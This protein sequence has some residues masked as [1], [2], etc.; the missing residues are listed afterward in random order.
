MAR[1]EDNPAKRAILKEWDSWALRHPSDANTSGGMLFFTYLQKNRP[2]LL[3]DFKSRGDK[4][5]IIN[6]GCC[7]AASLR[8][9]AAA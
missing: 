4:W 2:D 7:K 5:Q 9:E 1:E 8:T 3:L 6:S